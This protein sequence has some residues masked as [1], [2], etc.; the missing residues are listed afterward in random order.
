MNQSVPLVAAG[1]AYAVAA[2][3]VESAAA[4]E[5][6]L[7]RLIRFGLWAVALLV[8]GA[9][10]LITFLPMAGAV[11]APGEV[12][13]ETHVKEISHPFGGVA[14]DILVRDG[15]FVKRGQVL[16]RLDSKVAGA[17]AEYTGLGLDQLL[18]RAARLRA[19][20]SGAADVV[21][22][23]ELVRKAQ[24]P[25]VK[26]AMDDERR[27]FAL[28]R[29]ARTDQVRQLQARI[30][31]SRAD[32][33]TYASQADA[34]AR[35]DKLVNEELAQTRQLYEGRL[36]TLDR[37]N[38]LERAAVG[39]QAQKATAQSGMAQA[40]ARIGELQ[41]QMASVASA[42]RS[43]AAL[44]LAQVQAAISDL[45][46]QEAAASDQNDRTAIRAPLDGIVD[47]L[48]V[49]TVGGVVPAGEAL[50]EIV[51][52]RDRLVVRAQVRPADIDSVTVGQPAHLRFTALDMRTTPELAGTVTQVGAD[53]TVDRGTNVT[54]YSVT[55][56]ITDEEFR[57]LEKVRLSVGMPVESF[58]QTQKRTMLQYIIRPLSD[59]FKRALRE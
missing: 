48:Q 41:V 52:A 30:A 23:E 18:A 56:S 27:S 35:Q 16:I 38:A 13:V 47:K 59:Q 8:F 4:S 58:I 9:G 15:D 53:R 11:I 46:K 57:K 28:G 29:Q 12:T 26:A 31:Q 17:V 42:A 45:R 36:T 22:P 51:P 19:L 3:P 20:Q 24:D 6:G 50:M 37:L 33:A 55:V 14:S 34:Y 21:F 40:H 2:V 25:A 54:Y 44:E 1:P 7:S 32:I 39:V 10:G 5:Q 49:R 43:E